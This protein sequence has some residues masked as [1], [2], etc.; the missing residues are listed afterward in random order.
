M[1]SI[2]PPRKSP[3]ENFTISNFVF[4]HPQINSVFLNV[5]LSLYAILTA[6]VLISISLKFR[7]CNLKSKFLI[8]NPEIH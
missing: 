8:K 5:N 7:L 6:V 4:M 2:Y 1:F 3:L